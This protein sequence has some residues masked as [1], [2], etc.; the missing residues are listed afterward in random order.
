MTTDGCKDGFGAVL[1]QQFTT[2]LENGRTVTKLHPIAFASKRTSRTEEKYKPFLL[3]F[4]ALKFAL[5]RFSNITWGFPIEIE[6]DCQALQDVLLNDKLNAAHAHWRDGVLAHQITDVR[7]VPG[8]I[9]VVADELSRFQEGYPRQPGDGSEWTVC[10]DWE[11]ELGIV[12]DIMWTENAD[13]PSQVLSALSERFRDEPM[14]LEVIEAFNTLQGNASDRDKARAR[15]R[16]SRY[17]IDQGRLWRLFPHRTHDCRARHR[18]EC[19]T[20]SEAQALAHKIHTEG[21]HF[22]RESVRTSMLDQVCSPKLDVSIMTAISECAQCKNFGSTHLHSLLQPITRR[23]PFELLVGDYLSLP[24]GKGGYHTLGVFLDTFSQHVWA[25]K[26]KKAGSSKT[27]T[28]GLGQIFRNYIAPETFMS[29]GGRHFNS[30]EVR[31]FCNEWST[32]THVVSAYSPWVNGLVEGTNKLLLH[33]LKRLC[34]PALGEDG[35]LDGDWDSL[36]KMWPDHLD[37]AIQALNNR[38]LPT[39]QYT[40][41]ELLLGMCASPTPVDMNTAQSQ[42]TDND[43]FMHMIQAEQQ[44]LE[45]YDSAV[46]HAIRHK[47]VFDRRVLKDSAGVVSFEPGA[48]VQVY[49]S[50]LDYTFKTERKLLPKWLVPRRVTKCIRNSYHLETLSGEPISGTFHSRRLRSFTPRPGTQLALDQARYLANKRH[51]ELASA[52]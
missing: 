26:Y 7:H 44:R 40:P 48:L 31:D 6:T 9:N 5:D 52:A 32:R 25:F 45:G 4:A 41:K 3:E 22:G 37:S 34:A 51:S 12:N 23:H 2:V 28:D 38:I 35:I 8:H 17:I 10:E 1:T 49:R 46:H 24:T 29:D 15:H 16:T 43:I 33:I 11:S 21:G 36:P 13:E 50:D 18:V 27:T 47:S 30:Q 20:W 14:F 42:P 19:I 39:L